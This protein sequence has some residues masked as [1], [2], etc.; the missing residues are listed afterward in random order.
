M[1]PLERRFVSPAVPEQEGI[2]RFFWIWTLKEA[3]TKALGLGL[4]FDFSRI[5]FDVVSD[6]VRV[7]G[8]EPHG[9]QFHKFQL[10][11]D[12]GIYVGVVAELFGDS[13][14][15]V[16]SETEPKPWLQSFTAASFVDRTIK[17]LGPLSLNGVDTG[18]T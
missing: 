11:E 4:G 13:A 1:T 16:V 8:Q 6:V 14:T 15:V 7:D 5:E 3:Y 10:T 18:T 17:E 9:W 2:Q 12:D